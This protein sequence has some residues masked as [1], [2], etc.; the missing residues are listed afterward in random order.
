MSTPQNKLSAW[1][2]LTNQQ[3]S[4]E[5]ALSLLV[6]AQGNVNHAH[7]DAEVSARFLRHFGDKNTLPPA[8]PLLLW[9]GCYY[10]GSPVTL[11]PEAITQLGRTDWYRNQNYSHR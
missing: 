11:S 5:A 6:D 3:L 4:L 1:A 2:Q 9:R 8:I 10:L 7:L